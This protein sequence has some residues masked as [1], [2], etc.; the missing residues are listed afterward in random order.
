MSLTSLSINPLCKYDYTLFSWSYYSCI[1]GE[2]PG[3][4]GPFPTVVK[5]I[6]HVCTSVT[7]RQQSKLTKADF[8]HLF[9]QLN[10]CGQTVLIFGPIPTLGHGAGCFSGILGLLTWLQ[11]LCIEHTIGFPL[12]FVLGELCTETT[13]FTVTYILSDL[14]LFLS[15]FL[16]PIN[17]ITGHLVLFLLNQ[18]L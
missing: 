9:N 10:R 18:V 12:N 15:I 1:P 7:A 17:T 5:V 8:I 4:L 2:T 14:L 11:S 13:V 16:I 6:A 3:L